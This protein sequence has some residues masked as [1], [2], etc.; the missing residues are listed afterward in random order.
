MEAVDRANYVRYRDT[1]RAYEDSPLQYVR[2]LL[3]LC[4]H[5]PSRA[6]SDYSLYTISSHETSSCLHVLTMTYFLDR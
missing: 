5:R 1:H 6:A 3:R 2:R 4:A